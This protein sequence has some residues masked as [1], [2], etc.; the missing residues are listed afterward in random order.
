MTESEKE[1]IERTG[2]G[3][4][5]RIKIKGYQS[6][7][8]EGEVFPEF[9]KN[10][11]LIGTVSR[12][13]AH[14]SPER[15]HG[16]VRIFVVDPEAA[17]IYLPKRSETKDK[18]PGFLDYGGGEHSTVNRET[19]ELETWSQTAKRGLEEE[20]GLKSGEYQL[21]RIQGHELDENDPTQTEW[22]TFYTAQ[23]SKDQS[24]FPDQKEINPSKGGWFKIS[25]LLEVVDG[26]PSEANPLRA[27]Q[28]RPML[29][30]D[31]KI[32]RIRKAL[33]GVIKEREETT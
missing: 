18:D 17:E 6:P 14:I 15:I 28:I 30:N 19:G 13:E 23:V 20:I 1:T 26:E 10:G 22:C 21:T 29:L 2:K 3:R 9:N 32:D 33:K 31:L 8:K 7:R 12:T 24:L 4:E 16:G 5:S 27:H 25:D 11:R